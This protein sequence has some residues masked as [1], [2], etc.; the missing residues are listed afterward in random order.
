MVPTFTCGLDRSNFSLDILLLPGSAATP[1]TRLQLRV[2]GVGGSLNPRDDLFADVLRSLVVM[3][4][5]HGVG[6]A[7]LSPRSQV[8]CV[9]EHRG[10][11]HFGGDDLRACPGFHVLDASPTGI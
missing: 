9:S 6:R 4:E 1:P 8:R 2:L 10:Q 5:M 11:G 7:A 3:A